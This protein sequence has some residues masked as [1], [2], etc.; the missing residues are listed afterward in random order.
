MNEL[1]P[2]NIS[3]SDNEREALRILLDSFGLLERAPS[4]G[5]RRT[6]FGLNELKVLFP[7]VLSICA[8]LRDIAMMR[9]VTNMESQRKVF[10]G[11]A[12]RHDG[13]IE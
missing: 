8:A 6:N 4:N 11:G 2:L 12:F 9:F 1:K 5:E 3:L 7:L 13:D 10:W